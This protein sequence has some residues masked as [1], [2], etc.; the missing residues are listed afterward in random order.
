MLPAGL[1]A[2]TRRREGA[3]G[4]D[5]LDTLPF[6]VA[7]YCARWGCDV[8]GPPW[9]GDVA[10]VLPVRRASEAAALKISFPYSGH[11]GEAAALRC[12]NGHGAVRLL[13]ADD[14]GL[15][16]L[17]ERAGA[18]TLD[19][20]LATSSNY[21]VA[22]AIEIAGALAHQLSVP[23]T[24]NTVPLAST[25]IGWEKQLDDQV[26]A[27]PTVLPSA[28]IDRARETIRHLGRDSTS[29]MLHGDLHFGNILPAIREPWLTIDPKG[30]SGTAAY[31]A[32]TVITGRPEDLDRTTGPDRALI[33][34]IAGSP[35]RHT[36]MPT[37]LRPAARPEQPVPTSTRSNAPATGSTSTSFDH[38]PSAPHAADK[39]GRPA[40]A[41]G[42]RP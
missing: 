4:Q 14:T 39:R 5:W 9:H 38:W 10:L 36:S 19:D 26:A 17:M 15:V 32:F 27:N 21:T 33:T 34:R 12:F 6:A 7:Q 16:L 13:D 2:A 40:G 1:V 29:T 23:A 31:D 37:S 30:W 22:Q 3:A 20:I 24:A 35:P 8:E 28:A 41:G 11:R 25:T 18:G 42:V